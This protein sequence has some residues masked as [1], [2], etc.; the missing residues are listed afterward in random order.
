M[1]HAEMAMLEEKMLQDLASDA[2]V[3]EDTWTFAERQGVDHNKV[4]GV[5]KSLE[6]SF[7]AVSE[8]LQTSYWKLSDEALMVSGQRCS[9]R[10]VVAMVLTRSTGHLPHAPFT[11]GPGEGVTGDQRF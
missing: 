11:T 5:L 2:A 3:V 1:P 6:G 9:R 4:V 10:T 8:K 7:V